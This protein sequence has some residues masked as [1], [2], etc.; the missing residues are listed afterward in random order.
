MDSLSILCAANGAFAAR[1]MLI[2]CGLYTNKKSTLW[3]QA[4]YRS[5]WTLLEFEAWSGQSESAHVSM[6]CCNHLESLSPRQILDIQQR[7]S[8]CWIPRLK[9]VT[10][11]WRLQICLDS[12]RDDHVGWR[13]TMPL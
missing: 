12:D 1:S 13:A 6:P 8:G 2:A 3:S 7:G 10:A 5:S 9:G 11:I 4:S